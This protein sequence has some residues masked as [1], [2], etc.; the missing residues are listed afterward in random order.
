MSDLHFLLVE[1]QTVKANI[2]VIAGDWRGEK[3][4]E[5]RMNK[6]SVNWVYLLREGTSD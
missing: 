5:S 6:T 2:N 4:A 1:P 3:R